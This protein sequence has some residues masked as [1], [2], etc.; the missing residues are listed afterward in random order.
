MF[1]LLI[2]VLKNLKIFMDCKISAERWYFSN[3]AV[4]VIV[5]NY[6]FF[7]KNAAKPQDF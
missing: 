5:I 6:S 7:I 2:L 4:R 1:V 3:I